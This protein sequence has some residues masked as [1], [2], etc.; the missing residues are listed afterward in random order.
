MLDTMIQKTFCYIMKINNFQGDLTDISAIKQALRSSCVDFKHEQ[1]RVVGE[2]PSVISG[3]QLN[4]VMVVY[5][6]RV[7]SYHSYEQF[8][9]LE[10]YR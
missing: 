3:G 7:Y 2:Q 1:M 6:H 9:C 4:M 8:R 10:P 5:I